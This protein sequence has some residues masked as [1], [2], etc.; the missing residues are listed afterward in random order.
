MTTKAVI[1]NDVHF[2]LKKSSDKFLDHQELF[3]QKILFP[4]IDKNKIPELFILGDFFHERKWLHVKAIHRMRKMFL[5]PLRD[6][7]I[8]TTL[9]LGNHDILHSDSST[10]NSPKELL[11]YFINSVQIITEPT[12]TH[13]GRLAWLPWVNRENRQQ[14]LDFLNT[15]HKKAKILLAHLELSGFE[16]MPGIV[17]KPHQ[18]E[19]DHSAFARYKTVLTGHYHHKSSRGNIHYLGAQYQMNWS[20]VDCDKFFHVLDIDTGEFDAIQNPYTLFNRVEYSD[21][22][23]F[24]KSLKKADFANKYCR[25]IINTPITDYGKLDK[26]IAKIESFEPYDFTVQDFSTIDLSISS[27]EDNDNES[28]I[29]MTNDSESNMKSTYDFAMDYIDLIVDKNKESFG[30]KDT[31]KQLFSDCYRE[32]EAMETI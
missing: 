1:L 27:E 31:F 2:G 19:L 3:F 22:P 9:I 32:A 17:A 7:G 4:Y 10:V 26:I 24:I 28:A 20:D 15:A 30:D 18:G 11:G 23:E 5:E 8:K 14:A 16:F 6:R 25:L 13:D 21:R 12:I 29:M